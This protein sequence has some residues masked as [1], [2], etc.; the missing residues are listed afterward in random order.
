MNIVT[1]SYPPAYDNMRIFL[2]GDT[3]NKNG[4]LSIFIFSLCMIAGLSVLYWSGMKEKLI[5][6]SSTAGDS[7]LPIY[8]VDTDKKQ[9]ALSFDAAWGN[10]RLR[11][12]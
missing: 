10:G 6:V 1:P 7:E 8:S 12:D 2:I 5:G 9:V 11:I 4:T 3:M